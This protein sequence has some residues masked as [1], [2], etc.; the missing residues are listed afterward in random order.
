VRLV[1]RLASTLRRICTVIALGPLLFSVLAIHGELCVPART[2]TTNH[3]DE[4]IHKGL[5]YLLRER[6]DLSALIV[7]DYLQRRYGLGAEFAFENTYKSGLDADK[8]RTWGRFVGMTTAVNEASLGSLDNPGIEE[9]V[10]HALYCDRFPL[11]ASYDGLLNRFI[12]QGGYELT[13]A[14][15]ALKL[16]RD[17]GC[18]VGSSAVADPERRLVSALHALLLRAPAEP[19]FEELD[20]RYEALAVLLDFLNDQDLPAQALARVRAEQ[21][22]DGGFP[23]AADQPSSPHPTVMAVWAL[24]GESRRSA[25][26]VPFARY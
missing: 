7:L 12:E 26:P 1:E 21:Q 4:A 3:R 20:V 25:A 14:V 10:M 8:L 16:V 23:A 19:R 15:L 5:R 2:Q 11:P 17:H 18:A 13:H 22:S 24:L 6:T 9:L